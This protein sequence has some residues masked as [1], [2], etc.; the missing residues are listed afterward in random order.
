LKKRNPI[1]KPKLNTL[2]KPSLAIPAYMEGYAKVM[3][4][5]VDPDWMLTHPAVQEYVRSCIDLQV[6]PYKA[7]AIP[8]FKLYHNE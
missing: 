1:S 3:M 5:S 2:G 4:Q 6:M 7:E 8:R